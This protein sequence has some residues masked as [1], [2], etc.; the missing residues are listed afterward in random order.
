VP[1]ER[2]EERELLEPLPE[3]I[4]DRPTGRG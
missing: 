2:A 1:Y 4:R 3:E